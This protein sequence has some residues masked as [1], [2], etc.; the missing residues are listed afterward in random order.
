MNVV[1]APGASA[2]TVNGTVVASGSVM[3]SCPDCVAIVPTFWIVNVVV[4]ASPG[5]AEV[6]TALAEIERIGSRSVVSDCAEIA[7]YAFALESVQVSEAVI[8]SF[9]LS[10]VASRARYTASVSPAAFGAIAGTV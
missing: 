2:G 10:N 9:L 8:V 7:P 1:D 5:K 3:T 4:M 6:A